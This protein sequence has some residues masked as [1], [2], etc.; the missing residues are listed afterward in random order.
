MAVNINRKTIAQTINNPERLAYTMQTF[1]HLFSGLLASLFALMAM[2][3]HATPTIQ[4]WTTDNGAR[5]YFVAAPG[6]PMVDIQF[7]FD[8]GSARDHDKKGVAHLTN[9]LLDEGAG[10]LNADQ[11]AE[12][13][14]SLGAEFGTGSYR[15]MA[16]MKLRSLTD[17]ALLT[18]A[19]E[20]FALT[21]S[22]P[23]FPAESFE[24]NK[25]QTLIAIQSQL[26]S[27]QSIIDK[28]FF[29]ALYGD[30]PYSAP[31]LGFKESVSVLTRDDMVQYYQQYYVAKNAVVAIVGDLDRAAVEAIATQ[32]T[33]GLAAGKASPRVVPPAA[34]EK[35]A[36]ITIDHPS[37]QT[38]ISIGHPGM[39]RDDPDHFALYVGNH[40]LGGSGLTSRISDE[41]RN[42]RGLAY[43]AYSFFSP[44]RAAGPFLMGLQTRN[45]QASDAI[46]VMFATLQEFID[47]GP[48]TEELEAAKRNITGGFP[49]RI[50]SNSKIL[51]YLG[52]IG[53]YRLPLDHLDTY[54]DHINA[55]TIEQIKD[56]FK[57]RVHPDKMF[58]ITVGAP[59][60]ETKAATGFE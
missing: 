12:Q 48:T 57:R 22:D 36:M 59:L 33:K 19:L 26:Q 38:H 17:P 13:F 9:S 1:K 50:A 49:L 11:I 45:D 15:D 52:N 30:H 43:S 56:A 21:L 47:N 54:N 44:M 23:S 28:A 20:L 25:K 32:L 46:K 34:I 10:E 16:L 27:P 51:G 41:I 29:K 42:K 55:V 37:T 3:A 39:T 2:S 6:L 40:I 35:G 18:P 14:D 53:F 8:A 24:R 5:I 4:H 58:T 31:S 7:T 60:P